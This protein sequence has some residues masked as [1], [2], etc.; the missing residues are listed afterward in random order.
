MSAR[1]LQIVVKH[2]ITL[3]NIDIPVCDLKIIHSYRGLT[4]CID[5]LHFGHLLEACWFIIRRNDYCI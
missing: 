5:R 4:F 2:K 3:E 1:H